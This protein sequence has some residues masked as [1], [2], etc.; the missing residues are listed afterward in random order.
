MPVRICYY[1]QVQPG[2]LSPA[3]AGLNQLAAVG[4]LIGDRYAA[5]VKTSGKGQSG[6]VAATWQKK[7]KKLDQKM[8]CSRVI[9]TSLTP[10]PLSSALL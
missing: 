7:K 2:S 5:K 6:F 9:L 3:C 8:L 10:P 1:S 4:H